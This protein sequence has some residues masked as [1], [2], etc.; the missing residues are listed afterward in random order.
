MLNYI[1][2]I[3][4]FSFYLFFGI[5]FS[6]PEE[7]ELYYRIFAVCACLFYIFIFFPNKFKLFQVNSQ[8]LSIGTGSVA[9]ASFVLSIYLSYE[10]Q[11]FAYCYWSTLL[12]SCGIG[13][14]L[15]KTK[16]KSE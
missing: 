3:L 14:F 16:Y 5:Y 8:L 2:P 1:Q 11:F 9:L 13:T 4:D 10:D 15:V 6:G 12:I 7:Y